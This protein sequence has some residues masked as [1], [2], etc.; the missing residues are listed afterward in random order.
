MS[1]DA[2]G[3]SDSGFTPNFG[4]PVQPD[5]E[6]IA[7]FLAGESTSAEVAG[8]ERWL[9]ANPADRALLSELNV[10]AT[11]DPE[12]VDVDA[13]LKRVHSQMQ[14]PERPKLVVE[15]G[16]ARNTGVARDRRRM[17]TIVAVAAAA[18]VV[19]TFVSMD[20]GSGIPAGE[21]A[22]AH[23]Y[24]TAIGQ[25]DSVSLSDGSRIVLGP[26]SR[27]TVG[28]NYGTTSRDIELH[29]DAFF[30]VHHDPSKPFT[31]RVSRLVIE[32]IGT[33]FAIESDAGDTTTVSVMTGS[34]RL[35]D[36][37]SAAGSGE[38]LTAGD[39]GSLGA[40][41]QARVSRHAVAD[42]T[43]WT[44][45]RLVFTDASLARVTGEIRR[46][47]GVQLLVPDT[48]LMNHHV[49]ATFNGDDPVDQVLKIL[50]LTLGATVDHQ[51]DRATLTPVHGPAAVR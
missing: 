24:S 22:E 38:I 29:G 13:A 30:D 17:A 32:D 8:V 41:G 20:R 1:N 19:A 26:D 46:W 9:D 51:G 37:L 7:R 35:R 43:A 11:V 12:P 23:V 49:T 31:V 27:V 5:W 15:Q 16:T 34:V 10:A 45:G 2:S 36:H 40:D 39:L 21:A 44:S 28:A 6:A 25:R 3:S 48:A 4:P 42:D 50:G 47:Y 33:T 14:K 18:T